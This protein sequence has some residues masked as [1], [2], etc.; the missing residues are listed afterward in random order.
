MAD[1]SVMVAVHRVAGALLLPPLINLL[2]IVAGAMVIQRWRRLG[3]A[4]IACGLVL[5]YL[6]STP[7]MAMWL[8][9]GLEPYPVIQARDLAG[10]DA[11]V[12]LS[13]GKRPAAEYGDMEPN[14]MTLARL[15]YG[16]YLAKASHKPLLVTG[17]APL[18]GEAEGKV[19]A[20]ALQRDFGVRARW[21]EDRSNTTLE[22]ALFSADIL[23]GDG[24]RRIALLSHGW[25]LARAV[26]FFER[27]GLQVLPAPMSLVRYEGPGWYQW[28][29]SGAALSD[30]YDLLREYVGLLFYRATDKV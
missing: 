1:W 22:N 25:H 17:G 28:L 15:R 18:G 19:M 29:P 5:S 6:L 9:Q 23:K 14:G 3:R 16:A 12:V 11:I 24:V 2:P 20:R 30:C 26:P 8:A 10:V 13:G 4:L 7:Q 21:V 27:T